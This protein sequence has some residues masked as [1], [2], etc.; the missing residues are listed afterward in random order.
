MKPGY[1]VRYLHNKFRDGYSVIALVTLSYRGCGGA[2]VVRPA[3]AGPLWYGPVT[4]NGPGR[5]T[6]AGPFNGGTA[7]GCFGDPIVVY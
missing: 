5:H 1:R 2:I 7:S 6:M 3:V 4:P